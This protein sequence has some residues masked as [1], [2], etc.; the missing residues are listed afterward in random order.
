[1]FL[2]LPKIDIEPNLFFHVY[3]LIQWARNNIQ[4]SHPSLKFRR[5]YIL[6]SILYSK[7]TKNN[8]NDPMGEDNTLPENGTYIDLAIFKTVCVSI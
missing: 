5:H 7:Y 3:R 6:K 2:V 1:L 8:N 4:K